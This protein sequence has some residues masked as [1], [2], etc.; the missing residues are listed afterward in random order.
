MTFCP[1]IFDYFRQADSSNTRQHGGLG[2]GLTIVRQLVEL[3]GGEIQVE[4]Q[5]EGHGAVFTVI[6]P[7]IAN[8][9]PAVYLR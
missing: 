3:H 5:G 2:L 9:T 7:A 8:A 4:S 1:Y 6:L